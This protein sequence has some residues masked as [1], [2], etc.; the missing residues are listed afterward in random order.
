MIDFINAGVFAE[1]IKYSITLSHGVCKRPVA[2]TVQWIETTVRSTFHT[3]FL[4]YCYFKLLK[5]TG[6]AYSKNGS[7]TGLAGFNHV[8]T[9]QEAKSVP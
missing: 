3:N 1:T 8:D 6:I 7:K 9:I 4:S 2:S 5:H